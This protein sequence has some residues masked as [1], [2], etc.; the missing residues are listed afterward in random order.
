MNIHRRAG[1]SVVV[2]AIRLHQLTTQLAVEAGSVTDLYG[3]RLHF[4]ISK[5]MGIALCPCKSMAYVTHHQKG[6]PVNRLSDVAPLNRVF[7]RQRAK[8]AEIEPMALEWSDAA[9][10]GRCIESWC[11]DVI[12]IIKQIEADVPVVSLLA[13]L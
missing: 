9:P 7:I 5:V 13:G 10:S 11:A 3:D 1:K 8:N 6:G 4:P 2:S 12:T